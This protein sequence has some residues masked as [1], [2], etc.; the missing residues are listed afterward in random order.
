MILTS[1]KPLP[2]RYFLL[3]TFYFSFSKKTVSPNYS[4]TSECAYLKFDP[5]FKSFLHFFGPS[6]F[7]T[8]YYCF[9][10]L[11]A[12][13]PC[14]LFAYSPISSFAISPSRLSV[15]QPETRNLKH[16]TSSMCDCNCFLCPFIAFL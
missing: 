1:F 12:P 8:L 3:T 14:L 15:Y 4:S 11:F 16:E 6:L 10:W 2:N 7:F 9:P 5:A 13:S